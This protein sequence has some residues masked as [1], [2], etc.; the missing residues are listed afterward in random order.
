MSVRRVA[1]T[2]RRWSP[3]AA[4]VA[5]FAR[6]AAPRATSSAARSVRSGP[7][8]SGVGAGA[9]VAPDESS[10]APNRA[11][12]AAATA[13]AAPAATISEGT[14]AAAA[15]THE[16]PYARARYVSNPVSS[17]VPRYRFRSASCR[18]SL[19]WRAN[20]A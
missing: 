20:S 10:A 6:S 17:A 4:T 16:R 15:T 3:A 7:T 13:G 19:A 11:S 14:K 1:T 8:D 18:R 5:R 12:T 9:A 2:H